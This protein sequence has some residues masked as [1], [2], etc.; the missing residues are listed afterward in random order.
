VCHFSAQTIVYLF[1]RVNVRIL[2]KKWRTSHVN[3]G[4]LAGRSSGLYCSEKR[5]AVDVYSVRAAA[6]RWTAAY[7]SAKGVTTSLLVYL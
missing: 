5:S 2:E 4:L 7:M 1:E 3:D 6:S